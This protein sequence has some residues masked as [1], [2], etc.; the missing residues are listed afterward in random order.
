MLSGPT[1]AQARAE[2]RRRMAEQGTQRLES[3]DNGWW[4]RWWEPVDGEASGSRRDR[5]WPRCTDPTARSLCS[6]AGTAGDWRMSALPPIC[7]EPP[8]DQLTAV[9]AIAPDVP[10]PTMLPDGLPSTQTAPSRSGMFAACTMATSRFPCVSTRI[11]RLRP[12]VLFSPIEAALS[13][14]FGRLH[15]L[16]VDDPGTRLWVAA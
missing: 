4:S 14:G 10:E 7:E 16:A 11:W 13:P 8:L 1:P 5:P 6:G 9:A 3:C 15:T 12:V 2:R